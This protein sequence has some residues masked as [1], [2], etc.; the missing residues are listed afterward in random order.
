[1]M[2]RNKEALECAKEWYCLWLTKH[3]HPPAIDAAFA[4]IESCVHNGEYDDARLYAHTTW[5]TI[6][7][8]RDS[9]IPDSQREEFTARGAHY[10]AKSIFA[11]V[12]SGGIP[13]EEKEE[14]GNEA[15]ARARQALDTFSRLH[16]I[17]RKTVA[18]AKVMLAQVLNFF[19]EEDDD[20]AIQ[21][22]EQ[23][24]AIYIQ[25]QGNSS[26]KVGE[27]EEDLGALYYNKA[28]RALE[29]TND[30]HNTLSYV[31]LSLPRLREAVRIYRSLGRLNKE[32]D[33]S[34]KMTIEIEGLRQLI[35]EEI[36]AESE[37]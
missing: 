20:E 10:V 37:S 35:I 18:M 31:D 24:K 14:A 26:I 21:L 7:L 30:L 2:D 6:T 22:F 1:M 25:L 15:I 8:S 3:T 32:V 28:K 23:S 9:H 33:R 5:E 16:G 12:Q 34:I 11:M 13:A 17:E 36:V 19:K 27:I 4:L 29:G